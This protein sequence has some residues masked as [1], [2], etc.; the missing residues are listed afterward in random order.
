MSWVSITDATGIVSEYPVTIPIDFD[1]Y[2]N[3]SFLILANDPRYSYP[4]TPTEKMKIAQS[5]YACFLGSPESGRAQAIRDGVQSFSVGSFSESYT[6]KASERSD[7]YPDTIANLLQEYRIGRGT[8]I[9]LQ[10]TYPS[11]NPSIL[12]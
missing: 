4:D 5:L 3:K 6:N 10:R 8:S 9:K 1:K 7:Q 12:L 11:N 2:L